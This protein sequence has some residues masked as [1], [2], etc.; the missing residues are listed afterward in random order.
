MFFTKA[1]RKIVRECVVLKKYRKQNKNKDFTIISQN[2][3]GGVIYAD[4]DLEFKT[5]T[6]NMF[7]EDENFV[8]LVENFEYYMQIEAVPKCECYIDPIDNKIRY[9]KIAIGDIEL[10]CIHYKNCQ[11][12]IEAWERRKKRVNYNNI[13]VIA[14]T[15]NL[16]E[17]AEL[18]QRLCNTKYKTI[19]F[20]TQDYD[21]Q[22]CYKLPGNSWET[23]C[24]GIVRPN[25][26]DYPKGSFNRYFEEFF[27]FVDW[28][29]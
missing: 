17:N 6:I 22:Q 8:K 26:T 3:V 18:V 28:L 12:A 27:D 7:I 29:N 5:P 11:E 9:P 23:D 25:L 14:N 10:C 20:T 19:I 4:L 13:Y 2:C 21:E 16:H 24:R 15:W 1:I